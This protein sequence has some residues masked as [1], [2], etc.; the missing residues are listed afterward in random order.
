MFRFFGITLRKD[1]E[2]M[3]FS[4]YTRNEI[5][6][7]MGLRRRLS[8]KGFRSYG[9]NKKG[10]R[11]WDISPYAFFMI[12]QRVSVLEPLFTFPPYSYKAKYCDRSKKNFFIKALFTRFEGS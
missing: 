3:V 10:G 12:N 1:I 9:K 8:D 6:F 11:F 2:E 5:L 4:R 7:H